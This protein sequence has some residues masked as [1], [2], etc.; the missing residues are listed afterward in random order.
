MMK[1]WMM[2][3]NSL[4]LV[5]IIVAAG[6]STRMGGGI[7]KEYLP[8][9]GGTPKETVLSHG[10]KTFLSA[11]DI[12]LL[13]IVSPKD[14]C[15]Q[16]ESILFED[17]NFKNLS[18]KT[19]LFFTEG[20]ESRQESVRKA[21]VFAKEK[22]VD[23]NAVVLIHDGARPFVSEKIIQE[24][25]NA[26]R[27]YGAAVPALTPVDTQKKIS[28]DG[29]ISEHL[30]R[31]SLC[32][33][34]TPQGFLLNELLDCHKKASH[35]KKT[36]TD[37]TEI[38]DSYPECT[39]GKKVHVVA[40]ESTNKKITYKE[41]LNTLPGKEKKMIRIGFG[42]DLHR[43]SEERKFILGGVEIP[44]KKGELGHSDGDVLLHAIS[45]ALLGAS[46]L[47]DIGSYFP[48]EDAK[49]KDAD[50]SVLLKKIWSDV[51]DA[52]WNLVN[53]DCVV[54]TEAPK[55]L[56]WRE[57]IIHS[58]AAILRVEDDRVFVKAKTNEKTDAVGKG[59]AIKA[60]C[61]CLLEKV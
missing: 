36:F 35:E 48:P 47:G 13:I 3:T 2:K 33:V 32:A 44:S 54:E 27:E 31:S 14:G 5:V 42:T 1:T 52:G 7:K 43:L 50:S 10:A 18:E 20:G 57:K 4:P 23:K 11:T 39:S 40:G 6:S 24:T 28:P 25:E 15:S 12:S 16:A 59:D 38:W 56:P 41:D 26:V 58:I 37:D 34:Q 51:T 60:Y 21:L 61:T 17:R 30:E 9:P 8:F 55:I 49:W 46:H 29:T 45:D 22:L 19:N 53:L